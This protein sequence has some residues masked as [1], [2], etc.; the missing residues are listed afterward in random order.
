MSFPSLFYCSTDLTPLYSSRN[1]LLSDRRT[2][3]DQ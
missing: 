3:D 2:N 1:V